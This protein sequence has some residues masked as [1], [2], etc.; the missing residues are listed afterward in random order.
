M[1]L[2]TS[3]ISD[4][5]INKANERMQTILKVHGG[6]LVHDIKINSLTYKLLKHALI[7]LI[8]LF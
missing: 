8:L 5:N 7:K 1:T 6:I 3:E 2:Y 4:Q